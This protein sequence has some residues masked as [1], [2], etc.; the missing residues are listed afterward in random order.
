MLLLFL[1]F[2]IVEEKNLKKEGLLLLY[3]ASWGIKLIKRIGEKHPKLLKFLGIISIGLGYL[4]MVA[5]VWFFGRV[6]WIYL[7]SPEFVKAIKI[8]PIMPLI[9]Y[10]PRVF[11]L[12]FL[13]PFYFIYWIIILAVVAIPHEFAHGLYA[14]Y[15][16][17]KIKTTGFGFF[18]YF[19]PV[20]LAAFVELDE[21][22]LAK[23]NKFG[24]LATLSAGTFAN[25]L[26]GIFFFFILWGFFS[27]AYIPSGVMFDT[28]SY[29]AIDVSEI[30]SINNQSLLD[31][32]Y[33]NLLGMLE[34]SDY[35]NEIG[36]KDGSSYLTSKEL[37][38]NPQNELLFN[39]ENQLV[40]FD[41][42]PAIN[43][44]LEGAI[45]EIDGVETK[46]AE[47]LINELS[48]KSPGEEINIKTITPLG[49]EEYDLVL[50]EHPQIEGSGWL[51]IGFLNRNSGGLL[52]S[53]VEVS[54]IFKDPYTYYEPRFNAS[55]FIY[56]LL[57][58][59][60]IVCFS[61]ALINMLPVG[62]FDGGRFF[63]LTILSLT[64]N[65]KIAKKAFRFVTL[66]F[67]FFVLVIMGSW[68]W[69]L[70]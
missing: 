8:P 34:D 19:F 6:V 30:D 27:V 11:K 69:N 31:L 38:S 66:T 57:W 32:E 39:Q 45:Y 23:K 46:S 10:L 2:C 12:E 70:F 55:D 26:T 40:A 42:A 21:K 25:V 4:L 7:F 52:S 36:M 29:S 47:V 49:I 53:I 35:V 44:G 43:A 28:Y 37:F 50:G 61:I 13:P 22:E 62:I 41:N 67:L 33:D 64:G 20:F 59:L 24:Q 18:P 17:V 5:M 54:G 56:N 65:Q 58:W 60:V 9:P 16:K 15:N 63:Y 14:A 51:G 3:R 68:F 1:Y 48:S